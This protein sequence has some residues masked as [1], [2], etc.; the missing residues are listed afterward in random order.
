[1]TDEDRSAGLILRE[2]LGPMTLIEIIEEKNLTDTEGYEPEQ[3]ATDGAAEGHATWAFP[4][5]SNRQNHKFT[6]TVGSAAI[7]VRAD[8]GAELIEALQDLSQ[9][10]AYAAIAMA[11]QEAKSYGPQP[12]G[13]APAPA[14]A[15]QAAPV[16]YNPVTP[17]PN[18]PYPG[19][20]AWQQ[21]GAPAQ[22]APAAPAAP[23]G[24]RQG[25]DA[26]PPGWYR[27]NV[28]FA[29][30]DAFK[31]YREQNKQAFSG[32]IKWQS[33]GNYFVAP[34]VVQYFAQYGAVPA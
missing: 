15:P 23:Q 29:S 30:K 9:S 34:D 22:Y 3:D 33:G 1:M 13:P 28:P 27:I 31:A 11:I 10:G 18:Q 26:P 6:I 24:G 25:T 19:Q 14:S 12:A 20:P 2:A 7:V 21:A 5:K 16:N 32:K 4:P 8:S 17:P